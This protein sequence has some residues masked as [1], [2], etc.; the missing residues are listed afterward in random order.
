MKHGY[1]GEKI[2][3]LGFGLMRLPMKDDQIDIEQVKQMVDEFMAKGFTYFDTA[4]GYINGRSEIAAREAIVERYPR[5][6]YQLA[7]KFPIWEVKGPEDPQRI[8]DTQLERTRAGYFDFYLIH[9]ISGDRL[10]TYDKFGIWDFVKDL[11]AKGIAKHIGFSFHD[12]ASV[13]EEILTKHP[14][15]EFVQLQINYA[16]WESDDVEARK[17]HE[18]CMKH[19]IPVI[20]M[21]PIKGGMLAGMPDEARNLMQEKRPDNSIASWAMRYCAS[22]DGV[23]TVL[24][25][26]S[27]LDQMTDNLSYMTDFEP[28]TDEDYAVIGEVNKILAR[29]PRIPCTSCQYCTEQ[30]PQNI[31]IPGIFD[32]V[33]NYRT[34]GDAPSLHN[35]YG[36]ATNN[37]GKA[38]DCISCGVCESRCPQHIEIIEELRK[39]A[40]IYG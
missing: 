34:Y 9:A 19:N 5:E 7:T 18:V 2:P 17:C 1:L 30:C 31:N 3:K 10:E 37:R 13:L 28:M 12:K 21:E 20:I 15:T 16:D 36:F 27:A 38:S 35:S 29:I 33:N 6:S 40:E 11:K 4:F 24:S 23:I 25:G 32:V 39:A 14:E 8:I 22:L 26:M